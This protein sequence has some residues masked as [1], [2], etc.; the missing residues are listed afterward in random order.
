MRNLPEWLE[1]A[2]ENQVIS[3]FVAGLI[4]IE[5]YR[6]ECRN[7]LEVAMPP[8]LLPAWNRLYLFELESPSKRVH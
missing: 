6:P 3:R 5:L 8:H 7:K 4:L 1:A 2:A